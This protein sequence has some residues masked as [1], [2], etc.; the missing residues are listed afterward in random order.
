MSAQLARR[1]LQL[2]REERSVSQEALSK[3]LGFNDRQTL[4]AVELGE[5]QLQPTELVA[6]SQYFGVEL[7]YFTDPF[8]LAG[9]GRFSW[10]QQGASLAELDRV[11]AKTGRWLAAY[12]HFSRLKGERFHSLQLRVAI[13]PTS[14]FED[15]ASEGEAIAAELN[16]GEVPARGLIR[17]LEEDLGTLVLHMDEGAGISGAAC[18]LN[19]MNAILINRREA[20]TRRVFDLAHEL[21]HLLTWDVMPPARSD[22]DRPSSKGNRVEK[23][24]ENFAAGLLLPKRWVERQLRE[25][26]PGEPRGPET[27]ARWIAANAEKLEVSAAALKWRLVN[28]KILKKADGERIGDDL[29]RGLR[30]SRQEPAAPPCFSR[31]F[32]ESIG[33]GLE[34]GHVSVRRMATVLGLTIDELAAIF[35][36]HQLEPPF[37]L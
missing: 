28:L 23:L 18:R 24:A 30:S 5:R 34:Q 3:A 4:S 35:H 10:R 11:E 29:L 19:E 2:L 20:A 1:R 16:L 25:D 14:A 7:D 27:W 33:W 22:R 15:A 37:D 9:E 31:R 8:E 32:V 21:F 36:E 17:A 6:A 13:D 12:R 26:P